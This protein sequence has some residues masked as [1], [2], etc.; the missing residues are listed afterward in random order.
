MSLSKY[1]EIGE[2]FEK[3]QGIDFMEDSALRFDYLRFLGRCT[4]STFLTAFS[5]WFYVAPPN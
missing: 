2:W 3:K 4:A 5:L 1:D